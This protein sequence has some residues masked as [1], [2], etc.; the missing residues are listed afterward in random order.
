MLNNQFDATISRKNWMKKKR[1]NVQKL[2]E[3][4]IEA[5]E[6]ACLMSAPLIGTYLK[7]NVLLQMF[8]N[9]ILCWNW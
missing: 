2:P 6:A 4:P 1:E 8:D 9:E 5:V 3:P 7:K